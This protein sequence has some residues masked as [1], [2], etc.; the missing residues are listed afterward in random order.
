[1]ESPSMTMTVVTTRHIESKPTLLTDDEVNAIWAE[2]IASTDFTKIGTL[3]AQ[4][5][6][7][8]RHKGSN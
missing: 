3:P 2:V 1:M 5:I 8:T 6:F 4:P 7:W